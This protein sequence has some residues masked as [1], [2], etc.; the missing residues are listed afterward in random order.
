[1]TGYHAP[2]PSLL[3]RPAQAGGSAV[4]DPGL[5]RY[6]SVILA[7]RNKTVVAQGQPADYVINVVT[8]ALRIVRL[9][10]DGRRHI[11]SFL[12]PGDFFG[13]TE[14]AQYTQSLEAVADTTLIRYP[15][16]SLETLLRT[17]STANRH[18][19]NL[20]C[21]QLTS[22]QEDLLLLGRKNAV[23]RLASFLLALAERASPG[24]PQPQAVDL[25]MKR[26][27]I[28]DYLGM[29]VETVSRILT[30]L[31]SRKIIDLPT[32]N[33]VVFL[34]PGALRQLCAASA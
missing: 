6:G 30:Q 27:D 3:S 5:D 32:V 8:G 29:T 4:S 23:E 1:M 28:A 34:K 15:R 2:L 33:H 11:S 7:K 9:L 26:G 12:L 18:F 17:N 20:L 22:T 13:L 24:S 10:P 16:R 25:L 21:A 19:F 14:S 31:R